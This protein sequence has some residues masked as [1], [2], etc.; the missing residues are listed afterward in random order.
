M[1]RHRD[2]ERPRGTF[3]DK[4][5]FF[6]L[7]FFYMSGTVLTPALGEVKASSWYG[8]KRGRRS[9]GPRPLVWEV[10][11]DL[12]YPEA[13]EGT[14]GGL[15]VGEGPGAGAPGPPPHSPPLPSPPGRVCSAPEPSSTSNFRNHRSTHTF[16]MCRIPGTGESEGG[17][18]PPVG[19][20]GG[21]RDLSSQKGLS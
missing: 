21:L 7:E 11:S 1:Q 17:R 12:P 9:K 18:D 15:L 2:T 19:G 6:P 20:F 8:K 14:A 3:I 16:E 13:S 10:A 4:H 5:V